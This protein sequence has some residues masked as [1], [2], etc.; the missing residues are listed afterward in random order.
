[1]SKIAKI[2]MDRK[3]TG[4]IT[5]LS[6]KNIAPL[7]QEYFFEYFWTDP[8]QYMKLYVRVGDGVYKGLDECN[9]VLAA[10]DER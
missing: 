2:T 1:M 7:S 10:M 3:V 9:R 5:A 8:Q 6:S 4:P